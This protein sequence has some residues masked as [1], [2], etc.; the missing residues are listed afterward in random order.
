M[1]QHTRVS[2]HQD[3]TAITEPDAVQCQEV[4]DIRLDR[5]AGIAEVILAAEP[6]VR[7]SPGKGVEIDEPLVEWVLEGVPNRPVPP[8]GDPADDKRRERGQIRR[9]RLSHHATPKCR[10]AATPDRQP[11]S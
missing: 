3:P 7:L 4:L 10:A 1:A 5:E 8:V 2:E 9:F 6:Q 11:S